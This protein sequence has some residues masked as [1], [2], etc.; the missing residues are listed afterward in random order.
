[1][2]HGLKDIALYVQ[3]HITPCTVVI[4]SL[5]VHNKPLEAPASVKWDYFSI[6]LLP[7]TSEN[8][9]LHISL[10]MTESSKNT[11]RHKQGLLHIWS[12]FGDLSLNGWW[13]LARKSKCLPHTQTDGRTDTRTDRRRQRQYPKAKNWPRVKTSLVNTGRAILR[14]LK[15]FLQT[16]N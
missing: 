7:F 9:V 16:L 3:K 8:V 11:D 12:K 13:V 5:L 2:E 1:M 10:C 4:T 6:T 15:Q 14:L